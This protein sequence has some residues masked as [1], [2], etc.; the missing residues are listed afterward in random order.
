MSIV[1]GIG[2][3]T[4]S[5]PDPSTCRRIGLSNLGRDPF[6][7]AYFRTNYP[8]PS[9]ST[10]T[11]FCDYDVSHINTPNQI[12]QW[13]RQFQTNDW[14]A[15]R[16]MQEACSQVV[17]GQTLVW[18][19]DRC[20]QWRESL[21]PSQRDSL[22][23]FICRKH[24]RLEECRCVNRSLDPIY[25]AAGGVEWGN[26]GCWWKPCRDDKQYHIPS[27]IIQGMSCPNSCRQIL[28]VAGNN[29]LIDD[30]KQSIRC[31][32]AT[33]QPRYECISGQCRPTPDGQYTT[34]TCN[35]Q[36]TSQ[37]LWGCVNGKCV[38][39]PTGTFTSKEECNCSEDNN[40]TLYIILSVA[41]PIGLAIIAYI[42]YRISKR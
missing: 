14:S 30:F 39:T 23:V 12:N 42:V 13:V 25:E 1:T 9:P 27:T 2:S 16:V 10:R 11:L 19:N 17:D 34:S 41:G 3:T 18:S 20:K 24:P 36:C 38:Q 33:S 31:D 15:N 29:V 35:E 5:T 6:V 37:P 8:N 4:Q 7:K 32:F 22:G 21:T 28:N 26:D 40:K